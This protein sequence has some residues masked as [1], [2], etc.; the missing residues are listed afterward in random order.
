[1]YSASGICCMGLNLQFVLSNYK[2]C[3]ILRIPK[4]LEIYW[5][6]FVMTL[7]KLRVPLVHIFKQ[8]NIFMN[9]FSKFSELVLLNKFCNKICLRA[10][11]E[12]RQPISFVKRS[13]FKL[14]VYSTSIARVEKHISPLLHCI[15]FKKWM[16]CLYR[17]NHAKYIFWV[18]SCCP[19][20]PSGVFFCSH[21]TFFNHTI[22][23]GHVLQKKRGKEFL[24]W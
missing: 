1:M 12:K 11:G 13:F 9:S 18:K 2:F 20:P 15:D 23:S 14:T 10:L 6:F 16:I 17:L 7:I 5:I 4:H 3:R 8:N 19:S 22:N 21:K 24:L